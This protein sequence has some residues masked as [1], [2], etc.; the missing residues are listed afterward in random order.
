MDNPAGE[1]LAWNFV[2]SHWSQIEKIM[3]GYNTGSLVSTTGSFCD[4]V[5]RDEVK[6]FFSQ[7]PVPSAERSLR[8]AQERVNYCI[9]LKAQTSPALAMWLH[10]N[11]A[12]P[13]AGR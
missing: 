7:H 13:G 9:D 1:K 11:E 2:R 8:Q 4:A 12:S 5:M 3:A 6:Q 10:R